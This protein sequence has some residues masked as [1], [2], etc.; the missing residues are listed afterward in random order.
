MA[1]GSIV[2]G[3]MRG[4]TVRMLNASVHGFFLLAM[5]VCRGG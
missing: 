5:F 2:G 3:N 1:A 4:V